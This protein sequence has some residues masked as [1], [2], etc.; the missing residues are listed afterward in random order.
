MQDVVIAVVIA[1]V[2]SLEDAPDDVVVRARA[3]AAD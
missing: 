3:T 1:V 2:R